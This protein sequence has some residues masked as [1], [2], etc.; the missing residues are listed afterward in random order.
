[1]MRHFCTCHSNYKDDPL[2]R[3]P[4]DIHFTNEKNEDEDFDINRHTFCLIK[5]T[6][7]FLYLPQDEHISDEI[8][9]KKS[10]SKYFKEGVYAFVDNILE[11]N[12][13]VI[14]LNYNSR[15]NK[16]IY[17]VKIYDIENF[18]VNYSTQGTEGLLLDLELKISNFKQS[19]KFIKQVKQKKK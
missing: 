18:N 12:K 14:H 9:I 2:Y 1:M 3:P 13:N 5:G 17:K 15:E 4:Y 10:Y 16:I 19:Y 7:S 11:G 6:D 8:T